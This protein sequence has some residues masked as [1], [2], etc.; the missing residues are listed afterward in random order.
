MLH[1]SRRAVLTGSALVGVV[2]IAL[3]TL[4]ASNAQPANKAVAAASTVETFS[5]NDSKEIMRA[6]VKT[7]KPTDLL[8]SVSLE[9][10]ILTDLLITG[11][12]EVASDTASAQGKVRVWLERAGEIVPIVSTSGEANGPAP[13][14]GTDKDKVTFCDR[15]HTRTVT[16]AE[17]GDGIDSDRDYQLTKSANAFNWVLLNAGSGTQDIVVMAEFTTVA[18]AGDV[19]EEGEPVPNTASAS[20]AKVGNRTFTIEPT[21]MA[22]NAEVS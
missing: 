17:D 19:D 6:T 7:S 21:K 14:K 16:N 18:S 5:V 8:M 10:S 12:P 3:P 9:C 1:P 4:A 20:E 2:A 11:G 13:E 15:T 22:N